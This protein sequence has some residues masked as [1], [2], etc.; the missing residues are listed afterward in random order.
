MVWNGISWCDLEYNGAFGRE[1]KIVYRESGLS[2]RGF[3]YPER[4]RKRILHET[5]RKE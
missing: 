3:G 5:A 2:R 1:R 4:Q